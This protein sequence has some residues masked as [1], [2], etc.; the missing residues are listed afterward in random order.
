MIYPVFG[1]LSEKEKGYELGLFIGDG[2][3]YYNKNDRH[4]S[5]EFYLNSLKDLDIQ[6]QLIHILTKL[7]FIPGV[8]KDPRFN[9][10]R[11]RV[12]SKLFLA[13]IKEQLEKFKLHSTH[14]R[15][16]FRLDF[17]LGVISGFIDA[18][19]HLAHGTIFIAQKDGAIMRAMQSICEI[20]NIKCAIWE[21]R[22]TPSGYIWRGRI[23][24]SFKYLP[25][26]SKKVERV[27]GCSP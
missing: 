17:L 7:G 5:V 2:Y 20:L 10:N 14:L 21:T 25:H 9:A 22:N 1:N 11:I 23:S 3:L 18:E 6:A 26:N 27:Y 13:F 12:H 16:S 24:T 4:Y 8:F 19:G 15:R